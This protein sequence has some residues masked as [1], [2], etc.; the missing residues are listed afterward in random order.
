[1][2]CLLRWPPL[3]WS[4]LELHVAA[5]VLRL[6]PGGRKGALL[7]LAAVVPLPR[8]LTRQPR[9][10][11]DSIVQKSGP[12]RAFAGFS[13]RHHCESSELLCPLAVAS[14]AK[15]EPP[16]KSVIR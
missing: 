14:C 1:M 3:L 16:T 15:W 5:L 4:Q 7:S 6:L 9:A 8:L 10:T 11:L 12:A 2:G 13:L